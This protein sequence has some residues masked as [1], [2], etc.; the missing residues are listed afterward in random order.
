[1]QKISRQRIGAWCAAGVLALASNPGLAQN[2]E[3][4]DRELCSTT[5]KDWDASI[6]ACTRVLEREIRDSARRR[7][8]AL[9]NRGWAW[10][11]KGDLDHAIADFTEAIGVDGTFAPA[12]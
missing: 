5:S 1:M 9:T 2:Q 8:I 4:G 12:Y 11:N 7:A 3:R 6:Q 10:Q